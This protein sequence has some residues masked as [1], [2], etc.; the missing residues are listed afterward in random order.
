MTPQDPATVEEE[1]AEI[2]DDTVSFFHTVIEV[3]IDVETREEP[4][5]EST[6][7]IPT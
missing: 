6:I 2:E 1:V 5:A 7:P 3:I 4:S